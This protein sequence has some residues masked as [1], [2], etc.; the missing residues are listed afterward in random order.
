MPCEGEYS[1]REH[2][3]GFTCWRTHLLILAG[4]AVIV[5]LFYL[6]GM[7]SSP[8]YGG[9]ALAVIIMTIA[10]PFKLDR[11]LFLLERKRST[12]GT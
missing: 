4:M 3:W 1:R 7:N 8:W 5:V 9:A 10:L 11:W 2:R 6:L 12:N